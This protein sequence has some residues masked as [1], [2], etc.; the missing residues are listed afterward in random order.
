MGVTQLG[1]I[2]YV[3][4]RESPVIEMYSADTLSPL[5]EGIRVEGMKEPSDI[6]ACPHDRHLY[7]GERVTIGWDDGCIWR[8]SA[9]DHTC[10]KWLTTDSTTD[11]FDVHTMSLTSRRLLVTSFHPRLRQYDTTSGQLMRVVQLPQYVRS[12]WH[13]V[14]TTR[15]SF[16]VC[17]LGTL[18][19]EPGIS[20][21]YTVSE[22]FKILSYTT[23]RSAITDCTARRV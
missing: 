3:V 23:R 18:E 9:D 8:V 1:D 2:V 12:V 10:V 21:H 22:L 17:H 4:R 6:V 15:G 13:A 19:D 20:P 14:E 16:V 5:G 7:V 11:K